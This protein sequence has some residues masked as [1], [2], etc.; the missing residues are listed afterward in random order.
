MHVKGAECKGKLWFDKF[1][2]LPLASY[3]IFSV[4]GAI[5]LYIVWDPVHFPGFSCLRAILSSNLSGE[6][7]LNF[8]CDGPKDVNQCVGLPRS[9]SFFV[10]AGAFLAVVGSFLFLAGSHSLPFAPI[11]PFYLPGLSPCLR[12][13]S[14]PLCP[15]PCFICLPL[16]KKGCI[17]QISW[18][19][20]HHIIFCYSTGACLMGV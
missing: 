18:F 2:P 15:T 9:G 13:P 19:D 8:P 6:V 20:V 17:A 5:F 12:L 7:K 10:L 4:L 14:A 16:P 1:A 11:W 3:Y